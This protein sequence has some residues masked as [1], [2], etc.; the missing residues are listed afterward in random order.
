M[1]HTSYLFGF[2]PIG[3]RGA[4]KDP[5]GVRKHLFLELRSADSNTTN[6]ANRVG[7]PRNVISLGTGYIISDRISMTTKV[8]PRCCNAV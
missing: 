2:T 1:Q 3:M 6:Y 8:F 4:P 7:I 5:V